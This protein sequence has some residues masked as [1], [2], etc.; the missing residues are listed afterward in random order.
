M[1]VGE[2]IERRLVVVEKL[3]LG[4]SQEVELLKELAEPEDRLAAGW[5]RFMAR[6]RVE[7]RDANA[8]DR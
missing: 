6:R 5:A 2:E 7:K 8:E 1:I 4:L 3:L